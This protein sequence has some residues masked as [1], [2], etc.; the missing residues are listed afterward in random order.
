MEVENEN[1][2]PKS[3]FSGVSVLTLVCIKE[4]LES[5]VQ[6]AQQQHQKY[7]EEVA[8]QKEELVLIYISFYCQQDQY[9]KEDNAA[10]QTR[11]AFFHQLKEVINKSDVIMIVLDARDPMV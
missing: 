3:K 2:P 8:L 5:M 6:Q 1:E 9:V 4:Q 7:Q 11:R 10:V